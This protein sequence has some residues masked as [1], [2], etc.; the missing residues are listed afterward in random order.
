MLSLAIWHAPSPPSDE[1]GFI[2]PSQ[3]VVL[4]EDIDNP[5]TSVGSVQKTTFG[6]LFW[7]RDHKLGISTKVLFPLYVAA[8][9]AFVK[10][11]KNYKVHHRDDKNASICSSSP[12]SLESEL[13]KHSRALLLL[14]CDFGTAWSSRFV[15][16]TLQFS[17][18]YKWRHLSIAFWPDTYIFFF[19]RKLV[20]SKKLSLSMFMNELIFSSVI[21][22][23]SPKSEQAWSQRLHSSLFICKF[24]L[25]IDLVYMVMGH[26]QI[27]IS[28]LWIPFFGLF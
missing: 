13:M 17:G 11:Y 15:L 16:I 14:S 25:D 28:S 9:N 27:G 2:H 21:L 7:G 22:S 10:A 19:F 18:S 12:L 1:I 5:S 24:F 26:W 23:H 6:T 3:F 20:L 8:K 4:N